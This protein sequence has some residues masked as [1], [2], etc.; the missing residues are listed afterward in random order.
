MDRLEDIALTIQKNKQ[1]DERRDRKD[2]R[3]LE[4]SVEFPFKTKEGLIIM[5]DRRVRPDRR[6]NNIAVGNDEI[7]EHQF[8]EVY[9][10]FLAKTPYP[11][12]KRVK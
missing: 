7:D 1:A 4:A 5:K 12:F 8:E 2:R 3:N 6:L 10:K 9:Q 11:S